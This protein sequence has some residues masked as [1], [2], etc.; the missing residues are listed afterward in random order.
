MYDVNLEVMEVENKLGD[1]WLDIDFNKT[2]KKRLDSLQS[3]D[4]TYKGEDYRADKAY[5][6]TSGTLKAGEKVS[7]SLKLWI[8]E[9]AEVSDP[10][11][12]KIWLGKI[13]VNSSLNQVASLIFSDYIIEQSKHLNSGMEVVSHE[14]TEQTPALTDY[15]YTGKNPNNY[16]YFG[17]SDAC[18]EDNLYRIIGVIPTQSSE[19]GE[20]ENRIKLVKADY[21][22][23]E[24]SGYLENNLSGYIYT[25]KGKGYKWN[26]N[27]DSNDWEISPLNTEVL[28]KV[29]WN[30]LG[31]YRE[32]I[33]QAKW[34]LGAPSDE[35]HT[36]ESFYTLERSNTKGYSKGAT[37]YIANIGLM[38]PSDYGYSIERKMWTNNTLVNNRAS[39][40]ENAWLYNL[41]DKY[42]EW[43]ISPEATLSDSNGVS[44]WY[45]LFD[46]AT[47]PMTV[48]Y[49]THILGIRPT[50]Y[51][52]EEVLRT[53]GNGT[54]DNP[55]RIKLW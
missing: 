5:G 20:F 25:A 10:V 27:I 13:S 45:I 31:E 29:Y 54:I 43:T 42:Y 21:Y 53:K 11:M 40:K 49:R 15:R 22:T 44:V 9:R 18:T 28:N 30:S 47:Y 4:A 37:S 38:Y 3:V 35:G 41:E 2:G 24:E 46:G 12:N 32:F 34:Y 36:V 8:D 26:K 7:Y 17:C 33:E 55:Y 16:V 14:E 23:E 52:K 19:N 39:Y 48:S 6:L 1:E 51:L 50:F